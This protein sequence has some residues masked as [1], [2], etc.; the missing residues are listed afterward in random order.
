[1][2]NYE[3]DSFQRPDYFVYAD[4][5]HELNKQ[6]PSEEEPETIQLKAKLIRDQIH[7]DEM[8]K[9]DDG[10][11]IQQILED[12]DKAQA[13]IKFVPVVNALQS[14]KKNWDIGQ[15]FSMR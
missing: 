2:K 9:I 8:G 15:D 5:I 7:K 10:L 3:E 12:P 13:A 14:L 4:E 11:M 1:M 6:Y